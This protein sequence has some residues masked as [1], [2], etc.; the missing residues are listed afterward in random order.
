MTTTEQHYTVQ[1]WGTIVDPTERPLVFSYGA[2]LDSFFA[3]T[4]L[5]ESQTGPWPSLRARLGAIVHCDLGEELPE[6]LEHLNTVAIP[7]ARSHG[8]DITVLTPRVVDRHG[9]YHSRLRTYLLAQAVVP[10]R[11]KRWCS[12]RFKI[13]PITAWADRTFGE[14]RYDTLLGYDASEGHRTKR[15]S[16]RQR[17]RLVLPL[18]DGGWTRTAM[19]NALAAEDRA[20]PIKSRCSFCPFSKVAEIGEIDQCHP[21]ILEADIALEE[22]ITAENGRPEFTFL[23]APLRAIR[24]RQRALQLTLAVTP[25]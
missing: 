19:A 9:A 6:T 12:Q 10:S 8:F 16:D 11:T 22:A 2:G 3:L 14:N 15:L 21:E 23:H 7:Y 1:T 24:A 4:R 25:A 13:T 17:A 5:M 18:M 20:V